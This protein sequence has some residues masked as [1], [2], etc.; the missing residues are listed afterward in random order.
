VGTEDRGAGGHY[1]AGVDIERKDE[2][3]DEGERQ[4][5]MG[6]NGCYLRRLAL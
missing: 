5:R 3:K 2:G 6:E 4:K 1:Y